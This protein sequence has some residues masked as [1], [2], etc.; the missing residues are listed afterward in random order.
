MNGK[1]KQ[2]KNKIRY[3]SYSVPVLGWALRNTIGRRGRSN[4]VQIKASLESMGINRDLDKAK[5][6]L[7]VWALHYHPFNQVSQSCFHVAKNN[8][9]ITNYNIRVL[10]EVPSRRSLA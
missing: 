10:I 6:S 5:L 7:I 2:I 9:Y 3:H 1:L 8:E 4:G